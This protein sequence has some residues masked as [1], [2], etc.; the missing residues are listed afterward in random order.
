M[1]DLEALEEGGSFD[2]E[3]LPPWLRH[4]LNQVIQQ[5]SIPEFSS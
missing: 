5:N 3:T 1:T 2:E 4:H